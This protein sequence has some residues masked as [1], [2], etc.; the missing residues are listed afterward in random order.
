M[1]LFPLEF[2]FYLKGQETNVNILSWKVPFAFSKK[3]LWKV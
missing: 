1:N 2:R 3:I